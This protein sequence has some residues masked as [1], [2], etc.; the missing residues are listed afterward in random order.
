MARLIYLTLASLDGYIADD[1]GKFDWAS[2]TRT[3]TR[4]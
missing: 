1:D 4:S 3:C 2:R